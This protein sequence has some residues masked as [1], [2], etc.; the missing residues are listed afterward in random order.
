MSTLSRKPSSRPV[1]P[2]EGADARPV[3][4][5]RGEHGCNSGIQVTGSHNPKD[6]N[7]FK[8]VLAGR[9]IFGDEIQGLR[10]RME[11][12]DY[13]IGESIQAGL[14]AGANEHLHFGLFE[15]TL[16]HFHRS[17]QSALGASPD[18]E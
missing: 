10:R 6:Y 16:A 2:R 5:T 13:A 4:A 12:E 17:L 8:M 11:A 7:G 18:Q 3:A 15:G 9:A 1:R 14:S